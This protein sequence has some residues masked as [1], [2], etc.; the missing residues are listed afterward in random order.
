M[1]YALDESFLMMINA[2]HLLQLRKS[3]V[4]SGIGSCIVMGIDIVLNALV[5]A[6]SSASMQ[7]PHGGEKHDPFDL[8]SQTRLSSE[9]SKSEVHH[10]GNTVPESFV[11]IPP[12]S[13]F[14]VGSASLSSLIQVNL[15]KYNSP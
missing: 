1:Q 5:L 12:E 6:F 13:D 8:S 9:Q 3:N 15:A 10:S 4:S 11:L 2:V 14:V 7:R